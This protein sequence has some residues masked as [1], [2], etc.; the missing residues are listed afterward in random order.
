MIKC[1]VLAGGL[2]TR[3][4]EE[5]E[6]KPKP[7]VE[8][9]GKPVIWHIMKNLSE[10]NIHNFV[11]ATGYKG[12]MI[13]DFFLNYH[14][15]NNDITID[16]GK[17]SSFVAYGDHAESDWKVTI[18]NTGEYT[19]TGGRVFRVKKFMGEERFICTYGDGLADIDISKLIDFHVSHRK[20]A[21]VTTVR[22][23][24]R[25]GL[26]D[27]N[28]NGIVSR[29]REKPVM[30]GWVNAGFFVF[31]SK[32]FDF[33]DDSCILEQEPLAQ[34]AELGEL[35]AYRHEGFWQPMDNI[36]EAKLLNDLWASEKAP[37]KNWI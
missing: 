36:R 9:G 29:F 35:S 1:L 11:V 10:Q 14:S 7:M 16:L 31:E 13:K 37:W 34:L 12:E 24:S 3:M 23:L 4:R 27:V 17:K 20:I 19:S 5:T 28:E 18:S 25:F 30:D 8:I 21:T 33:L 6:F 15:R 26:M 2:G 22:P 32:I